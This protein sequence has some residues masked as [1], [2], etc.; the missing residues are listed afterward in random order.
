L[1]LQGCGCG[2]NQENRLRDV[3]KRADHPQGGESHRFQVV[4]E[5]ERQ[6]AHRRNRISDAGA[7]ALLPE[8][9]RERR[10]SRRQ[11]TVQ[12]LNHGGEYR[13]EDL[14]EGR[15][16]VLNAGP[17]D[18]LLVRKTV[19]STSEVSLRIGRLL[20]NQLGGSK[21]FLLARQGTVARID[22][23]RH[24]LLP[25]GRIVQKHAITAQRLRLSAQRGA[26]G[27][28]RVLWRRVIERCEVGC[29]LHEVRAELRKIVTGEACCLAEDAE[30]RRAVE[31]R[32][33]GL[34]E[35][36][37]GSSRELPHLLG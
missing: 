2:C 7:E 18:S 24:R 16:E 3:D 1:T 9:V 6:I 11:V 14:T 13:Q 21:N 25:Q 35:A 33:L 37:G 26:D 10:H 20:E 5:L 17:E 22:A 15:F 23:H 27:L 8:V 31:G 19:G 34:P 28:N 4:D 12:G 29:Q 32:L 30:R 36:A